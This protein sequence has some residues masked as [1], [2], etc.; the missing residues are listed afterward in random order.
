MT[1]GLYEADVL[2]VLVDE[3]GAA[4]AAGVRELLGVPD[5]FF[6]RI[7]AQLELAGYLVNDGADL[8]ITERGRRR[9][10]SAP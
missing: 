6:D 4:S 3:G 5:I 7:V 9:L 8:H 1:L 2:D 10:R